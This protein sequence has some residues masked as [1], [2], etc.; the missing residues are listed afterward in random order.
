[1]FSEPPFLLPS[2]NAL[3]FARYLIEDNS[4]EGS[5]DPEKSEQR[6]VLLSIL[7][8]CMRDWSW[9]AGEGGRDEN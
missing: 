5:L 1:M 2:A 6:A 4:R 7:R 8:T 9:E 3:K